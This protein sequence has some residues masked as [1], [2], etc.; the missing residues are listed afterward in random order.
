MSSL[1]TVVRMVGSDARERARHG[2]LAPRWAERIWIDPRRCEWVS[3]ALDRGRRLSGRVAGGTWAMEPLDTVVKLQMAE[4]HWR[5]GATWEEVG[6][7]DFMMEHVADLADRDGIRTMA[8]VVRRC[9][10]LDRMF[11][12]MRA[13]GRLRTRAELPGRSLREHRGVYIHIDHAGSPV[14]GNGGSHRLAAA[15]VLGFAE[16]PAQLGAVHPAALG[17]LPGLRLPSHG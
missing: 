14:F 4:Q 3:P 6:A 12:T 15:R 13:E 8:D 11:E 9:E 5:T 17:R 10:R 16:I 1:K 2:P 7:Y